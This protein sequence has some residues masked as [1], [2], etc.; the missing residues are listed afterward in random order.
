LQE[1][2]TKGKKGKWKEN[3][4]FYNFMSREEGR[5]RMGRNRQ[6]FVMGCPQLPT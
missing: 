3:A 4:P 6:N 1:K 5:T 2:K